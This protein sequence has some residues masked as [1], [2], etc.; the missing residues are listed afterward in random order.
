LIAEGN[1]YLKE[2]IV[3]GKIKKVKHGIG[4]HGDAERR[5]VACICIGGVSFPMYWQWFYKHKPIN[6]EPFKVLLNSGDI[7]I[8]SEEA[9]GQMWKKSSIY[10]LRHCAGHENFTKYKK[11][12]NL[13]LKN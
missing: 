2:K 8:M 4:W 12:W 6:M 3:D 9:V 1:K 7:Y 11:E 13:Y 10:T 5:K